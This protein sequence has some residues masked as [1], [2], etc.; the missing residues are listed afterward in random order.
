MIYL[1]TKQ[2]NLLKYSK[3]NVPVAVATPESTLYQSGKAGLRNYIINLSKSFNHKYQKDTQWVID[4]I[5]T[6]YSVLPSAAHNEEWFKTLVQ[7]FTPSAEARAL[8]LEISMDTY[9]EF[10]VKEG[11]RRHREGEPGFRTF[12][13]DL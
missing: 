9:V 11:T 5:A 13:S 1:V 12:L 7:F 2:K 4:G 6:I 3:S 8:A 10:L